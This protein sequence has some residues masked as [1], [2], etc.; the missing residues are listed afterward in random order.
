MHH[1]WDWWSGVTEGE[2]WKDYRICVE[3]LLPLCR[4]IIMS[5]TQSYMTVCLLCMIYFICATT[6]CC[7]REFI[8]TDL[9][10]IFLRHCWKSLHQPPGYRLVVATMHWSLSSP[11]PLPPF[12]PTCPWRVGHGFQLVMKHPVFVG[13]PFGDTFSST[14]GSA[15]HVL[16]P[17]PPSLPPSLWSFAWPM[18]LCWELGSLVRAVDDCDYSVTSIVMMM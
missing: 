1:V 11:P 18:F 5:S 10:T 17:V 2:C 12:S 15:W 7:P 14:W 9:Q 16:Y 13:L 4:I 6:S 3:I 8:L